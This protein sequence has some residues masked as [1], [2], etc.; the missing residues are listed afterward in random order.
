MDKWNP[1]SDRKLFP[2]T[3]HCQLTRMKWVRLVLKYKTRM[4]CLPTQNPHGG[5]LVLESFR[6]DTLCLGEAFSSAVA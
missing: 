4:T 5:D 6:V 3:V 1:V 2:H